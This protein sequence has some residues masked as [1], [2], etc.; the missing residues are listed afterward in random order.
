VPKLLENSITAPVAILT[1]LASSPGRLDFLG[2]L[3]VLYGEKLRIEER[4]LRIEV[5][6]SQPST[7]FSEGELETCA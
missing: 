4:N 6:V 7:T 2:C 1:A 5:D 3:F